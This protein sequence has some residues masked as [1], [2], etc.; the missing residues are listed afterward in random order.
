MSPI[1]LL[2][3]GCTV[4]VQNSVALE[5]FVALKTTDAVD[6]QELKA[7]AGVSAVYKVNPFAFW[8]VDGKGKELENEWNYVVTGKGFKDEAAQNSFMSEISGKSFVELFAG[9]RMSHEFD[10]ADLNAMMKKAD[11]K[12]FVKRPMKPTQPKPDCPSIDMKPGQKLF[13]M[14]FVRQ[15]DEGTFN[16][17]TKQF[18]YQ[19]FPGLKVTYAYVGQV[20]S[21]DAWES[22]SILDWV[23]QATWCE[24]VQSQWVNDRA[25][26]F[27]SAYRGSASALAVKV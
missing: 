14:S 18:F 23:D 24:Y 10:A 6:I 11:P 15:G 22:F 26:V 27:Y 8:S 4:L 12:H 3:I 16:N 1:I 17:L 7:V 5:A 20:D 25:S 9:Y 2:V 21:T 13:I 19:L